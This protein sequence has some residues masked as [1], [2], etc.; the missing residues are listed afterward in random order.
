MPMRK[1]EPVQ[2]RFRKRI[3]A[4]MFDGVLRGQHHERLRELVGV[5]VHGHLR[6]VHGFEQRRLRLRRGAVDFVRQNDVGKNRAGLE[7]KPLLDLV[8]HAGAHH[9]GGK[10][11]R[12]ELDALEGT[13]EGIRQG[14]R[15][16]RLAH[17]GDVF[18]Q[19]MAFGQQGHKREADHLVLAANYAG[20]RGL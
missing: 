2:L 18:N 5:V 13:V 17:S 11:V 12:G 20:N 4:V 19:Q 8:E 10:Q 15:E 9:V 14:L 7:I 16:G 1:Q 6:F 3:G